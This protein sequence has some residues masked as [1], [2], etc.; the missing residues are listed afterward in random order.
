MT[1]KTLIPYMYNQSQDYELLKMLNLFKGF[2][3]P[4]PSKIHEVQ[5]P[6]SIHI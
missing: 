5:Y 2:V 6:L 4:I 3:D 1:E